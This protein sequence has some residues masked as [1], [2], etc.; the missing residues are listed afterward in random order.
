[1]ALSGHVCWSRVGSDSEPG[2]TPSAGHG[3]VP[4]AVLKEL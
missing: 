2:E 1:M 3:S 4:L